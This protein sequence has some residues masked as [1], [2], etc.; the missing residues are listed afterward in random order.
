MIRKNST[1]LSQKS[2]KNDTFRLNLPKLC[3]K[4]EKNK[5]SFE[6]KEK[7][8]SLLNFIKKLL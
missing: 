5:T 4:R 7:K 8:S 6:N 3:Q 2:V 1:L